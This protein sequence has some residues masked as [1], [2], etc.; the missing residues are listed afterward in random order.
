MEP[1]Y[2][3]DTATLYRAARL[4]IAETGRDPRNQQEAL[5]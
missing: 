1:H 2:V 4:Q 3:S 5:L